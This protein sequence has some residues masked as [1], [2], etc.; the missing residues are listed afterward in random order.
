MHVYDNINMINADAQVNNKIGTKLLTDILL[1]AI[2]F[3]EC[4]KPIGR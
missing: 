4:V 1:N 2:F 3:S